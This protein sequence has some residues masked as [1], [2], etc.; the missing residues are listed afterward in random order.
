MSIL[1][2]NYPLASLDLSPSLSQSAQNPLVCMQNLNSLSQC[3]SFQYLLFLRKSW[4]VQQG[5]QKATEAVG[6]SGWGRTFK[7]CQKGLTDHMLDHP[8]LDVQELGGNKILHNSKDQQ[9]GQVPLV[10]QC[11]LWK[12]H[13]FSQNIACGNDCYLFSKD[14]SSLLLVSA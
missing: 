2:L 5:D 11:L 7:G 9:R 4:N 6:G 12:E 14:E 1:S 3:A 8:D 10:L 13:S